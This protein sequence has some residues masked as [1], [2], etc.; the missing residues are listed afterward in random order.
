MVATAINDGL[1]ISTGNKVSNIEKQ[2]GHKLLTGSKENIKA[3][4][5]A[6]CSGEGIKYFSDVR[7]KMSY[8]P[9]A[10][11]S[12]V[13]KKVK[14]FVELDYYPKNCINLLTKEN[15]FGLA[16]GISLA[17]K[18]KC[19]EYL[20]YVIR[21]HQ[22]INPTMKELSRYVGMKTEITFKN[23]P[24]SYLYHIA[25]TDEGVWALI[26]GKFTLAFSMAPEFYRRVY[27]QNPKKHFKA[28]N[29]NMSSNNL[30]SNTVWEDIYNQ[31]K[32]NK[33]GND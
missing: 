31:S 23:Q 1:D 33:N 19:D 21:E 27:K 11:V 14:S 26:P 18:A 15:G 7:T 8:A 16:G 3:E 20:D 17:D 28:E 13:P 24:R 10:V 22:K 29:N 30:I 9:I 4:N 32:V 2:Q 12:D 6:I 25:N 5:V